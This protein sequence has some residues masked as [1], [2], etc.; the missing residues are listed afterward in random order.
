MSEN[1][2]QKITEA[3]DM[4]PEFSEEERKK[5]DRIFGILKDIIYNT[6]P[7]LKQVY[8]EDRQKIEKIYSM[9]FHYYK[10]LEIKE[11]YQDLLFK[12]VVK[13]KVNSKLS[14]IE[15]VNH[16]YIYVISFNYINLVDFF[17]DLSDYYKLY[18]KI[19]N[20][21][22]NPDTIEY[23]YNIIKQLGNISK[24]LHKILY[25]EKNDPPIIYKM[26]HTLLTPFYTDKTIIDDIRFI[27]IR[28]GYYHHVNI[29]YIV[30]L[31]IL[32][33]LIDCIQKQLNVYVIESMT[34]E[35]YKTILDINGMS[36]E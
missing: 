22:Y 30:S 3:M 16:V 13:L 36:V 26:N 14:I 24:E 17:K 29:K 8:D 4:I 2:L 6:Y 12:F 23:H 32:H 33:A 20:K 18:I 28:M 35:Y 15:F 25:N 31:I 11:Y 19:T 34:F 7:E 27:D 1:T 9:L 10:I 5:N 21:K